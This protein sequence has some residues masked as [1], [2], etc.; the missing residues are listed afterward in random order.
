MFRRDMSLQAKNIV[1]A[2]PRRSSMG[3]GGFEQRAGFEYLARLAHRGFADKGAAIALQCHQPVLCQNAQRLT[4]DCSANA[5]GVAHF[6]LRQLHPRQDAMLV[7]RIRQSNGDPFGRRGQAVGA[8][9]VHGDISGTSPSCHVAG[10]T[11][12]AQCVAPD[13]MQDRVQSWL[14]L[15]AMGGVP[16]EMPSSRPSGDG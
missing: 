11:T 1:R 9:I 6:V 14:N 13:V 10:F 12:R 7:H 3:R 16:A 2:H 8:G 15:C 5:K 4:H